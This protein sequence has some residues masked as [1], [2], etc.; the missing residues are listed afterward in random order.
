MC[1]LEV[2]LN[3]RLAPDLYL[4]V[5][6]I[7]GSYEEPR[8]GGDGKP[9]EYAV[10]MRQFD[11]SRLLSQLLLR[12]EVRPE[13]MDDLARQIAEFHQRADVA[14][15]ELP[16]GSPEFVWRPVR[17]NFEQLLPLLHGEAQS[18]ATEVQAWSEMSFQRLE[19]VF[20]SRRT[21]KR[22]RE[23]HGDLH[24]GNMFVESD[25]PGP[26]ATEHDRV[27]VFDGIEFNEEFRWIDVM[28]DVAFVVMDLADRGRED[29][30]WRFLNV[31]LEHTGD[32]SGLQVLRFY[33]VYRAV[34]RAKVAAI[35]LHQSDVT[36]AE[37]QALLE[38][39]AAYL[40]LAGG[41][42]RPSSASLT[43]TCGPSGSGKTTGT[44]D[45]I[46]RA[47]AIRVRSDVER[48]RLFG[49]TPLQQSGGTI[50]SE[51]ATR[52]TYDRLAEVTSAV[53]D[54]GWPVVVDATFLKRADRD[55]FARLAHVH[56]VPFVILRFDA[57]PEV[58]RQRVLLRQAAGRD[59]SEAD[60]RVLESQLANFEV[61]AAEEGRSLPEGDVPQ[62]EHP[63]EDPV[64]HR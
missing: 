31:W 51:E 26:G 57:S 21:A 14:P 18:L 33:V 19:S 40:R 30:G 15:R 55:Q 16:F 59:A 56:Q 52:K 35:R 20:E 58:L 62:S 25:G 44:Q 12:G 49:L 7:T 39:C 29:L 34:V 53:L 13:M 1:E 36:V 24:L 22:I 64:E 38:E 46:E 43:I 27:V 17:Q 41:F 9:F 10:S 37:R 11:E 60:L 3:R 54:A 32:Y 23:C 8:M 48:K 4:G 45:V 2:R 61:P 6:P 50:Y 47:G 5:V 63:A 42:M 28:S